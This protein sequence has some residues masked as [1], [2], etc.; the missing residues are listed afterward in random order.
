VRRHRAGRKI[1][2]KN[3]QGRKKPAVEKNTSDW[4]FFLKISSSC[5]LWRKL[6]DLR[7]AAD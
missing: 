5:V 1:S 6:S 7:H 4:A 2:A 3:V